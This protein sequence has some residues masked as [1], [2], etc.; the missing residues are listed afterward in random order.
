MRGADVAGTRLT[1]AI[2]HRQ[3]AGL[4]SLPTFAGAYS[5]KFPLSGDMAPVHATLYE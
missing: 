1:S 2:E 4:L 3:F 5:K